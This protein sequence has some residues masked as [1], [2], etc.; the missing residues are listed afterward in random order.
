MGWDEI[1]NLAIAIWGIFIVFIILL[2]IVT[3]G[4]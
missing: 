1:D 2:A 4:S 3:G